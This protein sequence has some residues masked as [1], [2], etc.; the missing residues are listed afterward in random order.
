[1][2]AK[3]RISCKRRLSIGG[4][5]L[6][7]RRVIADDEA[8]NGEDNLVSRRTVVPVRATPSAACSARSINCMRPPIWPGSGSKGASVRKPTTLLAPILNWFTEGFDTPDLI[9]AK[10]L[11]QG[12]SDLTK[13]PISDAPSAMI[14]LE[15][16]ALLE[17]AH[18]TTQTPGA[19][20]ISSAYRSIVLQNPH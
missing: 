4:D 18:G 14:T 11:P 9:D 7:L 5:R 17:S 15:V 1:M 10:G 16:R 20:F 2:L 13:H 3:C 12:D 6:G 19:N 8:D